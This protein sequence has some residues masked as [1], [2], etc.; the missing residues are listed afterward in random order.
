MCIGYVFTEPSDIRGLS[1]HSFWHLQR[2]WNA[3]GKLWLNCQIMNECWQPETPRECAMGEQ[4]P[5]SWN[6]PLTRKQCS[7]TGQ[8]YGGLRLSHKGS[9]YFFFISMINPFALK[10]CVISKPYNSSNGQT[11]CNI[12]FQGKRICPGDPSLGHWKLESQS[13][14]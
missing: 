4:R 11:L 9:N 8:S 12:P 14:F 3:E 6:Q 5:L 10:L 1:I 7:W 13:P 2:S